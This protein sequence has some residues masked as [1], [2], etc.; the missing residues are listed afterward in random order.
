MAEAL[1]GAVVEIVPVPADCTDGFFHAYLA[2]P[3]A[4]LDPAVRAGQSAW[5]RLPAGVEQ[6]ALG[7]LRADLETGAWDARHGS[8]RGAGEYEAGLRLVVAERS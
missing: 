1:G 5:P 2:R 8:L 4:Y 3:E 7:A 6:R